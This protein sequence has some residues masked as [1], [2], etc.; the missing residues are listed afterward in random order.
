MALRRVSLALLG[1]L[2]CSA[3]FVLPATAEPQPFERYRAICDG[4]GETRGTAPGG[5]DT[6]FTPFFIEGT[7]QLLVPYVV[8]YTVAGGE[9]TLTGYAEKPATIPADSIRCDF[10]FRWRSN[11]LL[12]TL[13]GYAIGPVRGRP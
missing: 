4:Y 8:A 13:T 3:I 10:T 7:N 5:A 2:L 12:Y 9:E 6:P 11:G 1:G